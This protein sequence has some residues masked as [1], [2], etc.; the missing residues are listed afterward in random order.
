MALSGQPCAI[1]PAQPNSCPT[2]PYPTGPAEPPPRQA[3]SALG[4]H[5]LGAPTTKGDKR[6]RQAASP[7]N[8]PLPNRLSFL[9]W[10]L[11]DEPCLT[12]PAP[13]QLAQRAVAQPALFL[14]WPLADQVC[15]TRFA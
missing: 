14:N 1:S 10:P 13:S 8:W 2:D 11:P 9:N 5:F 7:D 4:P 6:P 15:P 3:R 12:S